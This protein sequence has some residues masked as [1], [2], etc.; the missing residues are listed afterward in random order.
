VRRGFVAFALVVLAGGAARA[1]VGGQDVYY[2]GAAGPYRLLVTIRPPDAVPGV[3]EVEA[4]AEDGAL[5]R[6]RMVPMPLTGAGARFAPLPDVVPPAGEDPRFYRAHLWMMTAGSWQVRFLCDGPRGS[7]ELAVPVPSLPQRTAGMQ[8]ALA[9]LLMTLLVLL[10]TGLVSIVG[11]AVREGQ[12]DADV[13]PDG[14]RR[15]RARFAMA[16][17]ALVV[18]A[19]LAFG[20]HWWNSEASG[21]ARYVYKPLV[22]ETKLD[23]P[24]LA[25]TLRDPGWLVP[26][27]LDDWVPDHGHLMHLFLV[28]TPDLDRVYHLHPTASGDGFRQL[29]PALDAGRY[30]LFADVVHAS[31]LPET[32][33]GDIDLPAISGDPPAGDDAGGAPGALAGDVAALDG[34]GRMIWLRPAGPLTARVL[35]WFRFRVE[36]EPGVPAGDLELY[37]GMLGH[38]AFVRKDGAVFAHVHPS[39]SVPMAA[40][41]VAGGVDPHAAHHAAGGALPAEVAFPYGLPQPGDYRI[42]VQVKRGGRVQTAAFDAQ[43]AR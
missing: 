1:H 35:T 43:V 20:D 3:A 34:G 2:E 27:R 18:L 6:M 38:A 11:A 22:L 28:R 25:L 19:T 5:A 15:A 8:R 36:A 29:L 13:A 37:M 12:L 21:Y 16:V 30:R 14:R 40:L 10:G 41:A 24:D 4:R 17:T 32:A 31:G 23:G 39:G 7:G 33:V 42:F 9:V 26:R